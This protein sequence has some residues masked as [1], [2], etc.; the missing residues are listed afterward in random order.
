MDLHT[1]K[2]TCAQRDEHHMRAQG[3]A[4]DR[5]IS[6]MSSMCAQGNIVAPQLYGSRHKLKAI[7][8][9]TI[10]ECSGHFPLYNDDYA[11]KTALQQLANEA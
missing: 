7:S 9:P 6:A 10:I 5:C 11:V 2:P 3:A 8:K 1:G 4:A